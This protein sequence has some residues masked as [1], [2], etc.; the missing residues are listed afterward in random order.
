MDRKTI[1][2]S[3]GSVV[4]PQMTSKESLLMPIPN[5][6]PILYNQCPIIEL[7]YVIVV[8]LDIPGS[9]D[10]HV[11]LPVIITNQELPFHCS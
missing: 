9:I 8:T 11:E 4:S 10:L 1:V 7:N 5:G 6:L 3:V 2:N